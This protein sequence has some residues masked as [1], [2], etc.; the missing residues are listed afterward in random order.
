[1][2]D[3]FYGTDSAIFDAERLKD[4]A[5]LEL[6]S[7]TGVLGVLLAPY[8]G[9]YLVTD[10]PELVPLME[11]NINYNSLERPTAEVSNAAAAARI[12][13][14]SLAKS[15][16]P[17]AKPTAAETKTRSGRVDLTAQPLDW[18]TIASTIA[19]SNARAWAC[20]HIR[21]DVRKN[22]PNDP[23]AFDGQTRFDLILAVDTLYNTALISPFLA[24]LDEFASKG[25]LTSDGGEDFPPTLVVVVCELRDEDVLREFLEGW[26]ELPGWE[27]WR[28]GDTNTDGDGVDDVARTF[29]QGPFVVWAGWKA[30]EMC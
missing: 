30:T 7:G 10:L 2:A 6:G 26:L 3:I 13:P 20:S 17:R 15:R 18:V 4:I 1:M 19:G 21:S 11:K 12:P 28:V 22:R 23:S 25:S 14:R 9:S 29:M 27:I 24:V 8:V 16:K 5:V